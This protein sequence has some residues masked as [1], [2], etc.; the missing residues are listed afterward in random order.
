[1]LVGDR[2]AGDLISAVGAQAV[3]ELADVQRYESGVV[4][5]SYRDRR[6]DS[7]AG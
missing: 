1:L 6:A 5:L 4:V 7:M 3:F 2:P